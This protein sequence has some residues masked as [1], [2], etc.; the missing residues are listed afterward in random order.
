MSLVPWSCSAE[1]RLPVAT[2]RDLI[3]HYYPRA[4]WIP[5]REETLLALQRVKAERGLP[6]LDATV[7]ELLDP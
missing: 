6:T 1:Y 2:W 4:G 5:L 7:A 3:E